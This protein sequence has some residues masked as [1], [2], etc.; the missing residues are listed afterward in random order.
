MTDGRVDPGRAEGRAR[1]DSSWRRELAVAV[2]VAVVSFVVAADFEFFEAF[3]SWSRAYEAW[4]VDEVVVA[5]VISVASMGVFSW[6]RYREVVAEARRLESA[7]GALADTERRSRSLFDFNP[8]AIVALDREGRVVEVNAATERLTGYPA[9]ELRGAHFNALIKSEDQPFASTAFAQVLGGDPIQVDVRIVGSDGEDVELR[10]TALP[11]VVEGEVVGT[12]D[13][14]EDIT[15]SNRMRRDL[16]QS[17]RAAEAANE[18]KSLFLANMSHEI[19]TPL[20]ALLASAELLEDTELDA[21]QETLLSRMSRSGNRL[22][23]LV[24]ELLDFSRIEAGVAQ[25]QHAPFNLVEVVAEVA[26]PARRSAQAQQ[27]NFRC[28]LSSGLPDTVHGDPARLLQVLSNLLSNAMKFTDQ[29]VVTLSVRGS[30]RNRTPGGDPR[31]EPG[32]LFAVSD[33][34]IGLHSQDRERVFD[35]FAQVDASMTR[36]YDGSGLGLA[37]CKQLV[38]QMGGTIWVDS[39]PMQGSTFSFWLPLIP[40]DTTRPPEDPEA[41]GG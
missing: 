36:R 23:R 13:M 35:S 40:P 31:E 10:A 7:E 5:L 26:E 3:A 39:S 41:V 16:E 38:T 25:I 29:G 33:T 15:V 9:S 4:D 22:L 27:L 32:V 8:L 19:R 14:I 11:I 21:A 20:T 28:D 17:T 1:R 18:A 30:A 24:D 37:I 12:Y 2:V 6:R 34:G